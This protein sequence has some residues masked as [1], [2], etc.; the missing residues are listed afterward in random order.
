M[1]RL[2]HEPE[3]TRW[4]RKATPGDPLR[5]LVSACLTGR[6]C[7]VNGTDYGLGGCVDFLTRLPNVEVVAFCPEEHALGTPRTTPDLH[8]GDGFRVLDGEARVLDEHGS[9]L[10]EKMCEGA[11]AMAELARQAKVEL[12]ILVDMSGACGTQVISEGCRFDTPRRFQQ[13]VGVAAAALLRDGVPVVSQRDPRTL[14]LV[15]AHLDP[16]HTSDASLGDYHHTDWYRA[17]FDK[18]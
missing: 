3:P 17:T 8:G 16:S 6:G 7:G 18:P 5:V 11:R 2:P 9:D 12:A 14:D 10:T 13:G 4:L 1:P 15:F